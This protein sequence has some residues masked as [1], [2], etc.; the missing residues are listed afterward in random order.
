MAD[1]SLS[2]P[3]DEMMALT[4]ATNEI[5]AGEEAVNKY[6]VRNARALSAAKSL[7]LYKN[8]IT[9]LPVSVKRLKADALSKIDHSLALCGN[10]QLARGEKQLP[11]T[12]THHIVSRTHKLAKTSRDILFAWRIGIDDADNGV[13]LPAE[14]LMRILGLE[15]ANAHDPIHTKLY[16]LTVATRLIARISGDATASRAE[17]G[18]MRDEMVAG[19]FPC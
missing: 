18:D 1:D 8:G 7:V 17:L 15:K 9:K 16:H 12:D 10:V 11:G 4:L 13:F 2:L 3:P 14:S 19:V 6:A 5:L